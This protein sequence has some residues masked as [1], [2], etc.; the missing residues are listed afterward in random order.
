M[1]AY[2]SNNLGKAACLHATSQLEAQGFLA[3]GSMNPIAVI[4]NGVSD[5]WLQSVGNGA[6][7][8]TKYDLA[9]ARRLLLYVGRITPVKHLGMFIEAMANL[10]EDLRDW[11]F[12]IVGKDEFAH[13]R[14]VEAKIKCLRMEPWVRFVGSVPERD[15]R[16]AY[17]AAELFVLPS[18]REASPIVVLEALGA[19]VPVLTTKGVPWEDLETYGCGW[20]PECGVDSISGALRKAVSKSTDELSAMG[21]RG[22]QLVYERYTWSL[23]AQRS[24]SLCEWLLGRAGE[25]EFIF[26]G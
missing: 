11:L 25:P 26:D 6:D 12:V 7:F 16:N 18:Y 4:H 14:E 21:Q 17:D 9:D 10:K 13:Q 19:A 2:E 3:Y 1:L 20:R 5:K 24:L 22:R 23:A 8:R 15:K